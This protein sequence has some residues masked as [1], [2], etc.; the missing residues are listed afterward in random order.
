MLDAR[1][2]EMTETRS[3]SL[4]EAEETEGKQYIPEDQ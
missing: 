3:V 2:L 1:S 4:T